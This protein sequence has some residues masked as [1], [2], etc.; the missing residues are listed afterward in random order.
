MGEL[1]LAVGRV[2]ENPRRPGGLP[3]ELRPPDAVRRGVVALVG[4]GHARRDLGAGILGSG[5]QSQFPGTCRSRP[6]GRA[7]LESNADLATDTP[8]VQGRINDEP[9]HDRQ[10]Q[11]AQPNALLFHAKKLPM[12][13]NLA[14]RCST[15]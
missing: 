2:L 10:E 12:W 8:G 1:S 9:D 3:H 7:P 14:Y 15:S 6:A 5:P 4:I 11:N 13:R